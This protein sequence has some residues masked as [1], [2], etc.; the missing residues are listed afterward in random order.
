MRA[1]MSASMRSGSAS[2][3]PPARTA[4]ASSDSSS[5]LPRARSTRR[6][7]TALGSRA[8]PASHERGA[9][10][11]GQRL[12]REHP[13]RRKLRGIEARV[14]VAA[15]DDHAPAASLRLARQL[16]DHPRARLVEPV[17][18]LD[19]HDGA[20][21]QARPDEPRDARGD[22]P[23]LGGG[24]QVA[25]RG[26]RLDVEA[27]RGA[28]QRVGGLRVLARRRER[29]RERGRGVRRRGVG[30]NRQQLSQAA[31]EHPVGRR[32]A[33]GAPV[34]PQPHVVAERAGDEPRLA[35]ARPARD[36]DDLPRARARAA[37]RVEQ[38]RPLRLA[39]DD[40]GR[41][42]LPPATPGRTHDRGVDE[43]RLALGG[44]RLELLERPR[45]LRRVE[46]RERRQHA[47]LR[48]AM[49]DACG[50]V[51]GVAHDAPRAPAA[52]RHI[53][54]EPTAG[55]GAARDRERDV[56]LD[57][58]PQ[59]AEQRVRI[60]VARARR[61]RHEIGLEPVGRAVQRHDG[62]AELGARRVDAIDDGL[63]RRP[64]GGAIAVEQLVQPA[65]DDEPRDELPMLAL[66]ALGQVAGQPT[67]QSH[68]R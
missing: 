62:D 19:E 54:H 26:G 47:L 25:G 22:E 46:R 10:G 18:V 67:R 8:P 6:P 17:G 49:G 37:L 32:D 3:S 56:D 29:V 30:G 44:E 45:D 15:G 50:E 48:R 59:R 51:R 57:D 43:R 65:H 52:H 38:H 64:R 41:R 34:D 61:A 58:R 7:T 21:L 42:R 5:G 63:H 12:D 1:A 36:D 66:A 55:G 13:R 16:D 24:V 28:D 20:R 2:G 68:G 9:V 11:I 4:R 39:A 35:E 14:G 40:R 31:V 27:E 33:V 53:D 23:A 60:G